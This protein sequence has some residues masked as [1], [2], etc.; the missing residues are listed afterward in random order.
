[1]APEAKRREALDFDAS[2]ET[3]VSGVLD[4]YQVL[5][6]ATHAL[7]NNDHPELSGLV[8]SLVDGEGRSRDGFLRLNDIYNLRLPAE[9]VVL[10]ACR[11]GLGKE[12]RGEGLIPLT[13]GFM[14]AGARRVLTSLWQVDD[15]GTSELMARFLS[16]AARR[17]SAE[18]RRRAAIGA[19]RDVAG[20]RLALAVLLGGVHRAG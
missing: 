11:T 5:H 4:G 6:F 15:A 2:R 20:T 7:I 13:R 10:S 9:L 1:M 12:M 18:C 16:I 19:D 17:S 14:Y 3:A 8:L